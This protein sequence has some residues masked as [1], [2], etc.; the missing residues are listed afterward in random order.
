MRGDHGNIVFSDS[1]PP[2]RWSGVQRLQS[3]ILLLSV[4]ARS[5]SSPVSYSVPCSLN[6]DR[7]HHG[8]NF[9]KSRLRPA[10]L[11]RSTSAADPA[12]IIIS[13]SAVDVER[14]D[15]EMAVAVAI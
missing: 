1:F 4:L 9:F 10:T 11:Q 6:D 8:S 3:R 15:E 7:R 13:S 14:S 5:R 12:I 2:W